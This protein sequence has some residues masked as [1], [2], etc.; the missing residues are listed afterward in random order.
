MKKLLVIILVLISF[1]SYA[2]YQNYDI[3]VDTITA[4]SDC[5]LY[6][7]SQTSYKY[8]N[9][10]LIPENTILIS[11]Y[12]NSLY[13]KVEYENMIGYVFCMSV[14]VPERVSQ[15]QKMINTENF[16]KEIVDSINSNYFIKSDIKYENIE[17]I[18]QDINIIN[19]ELNLD[20]EDK[21][22]TEMIDFLYL[23]VN[24]FM[25]Y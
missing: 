10:T 19:E 8:D 11:T 9:Q 13:F 21:F 5:Y 24:S 22:P 25:I 14:T 2:Q 7:N 3:Y 16:S 15:I 18:N 17:N 23:F 1:F 20:M 4:K 6:L 12:F